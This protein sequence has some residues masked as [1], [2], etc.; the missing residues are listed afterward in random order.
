MT[1][2]QSQTPLQVAL[3]VDSLG[4]QYALRPRRVLRGHF[5]K[6]YSVHWSADSQHLVSASQ[7]G[8]LIVW[9]AYNTAKVRLQVAHG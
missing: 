1:A 9:D 5:G 6:I 3:G 2:P 4:S 8:K 7:D